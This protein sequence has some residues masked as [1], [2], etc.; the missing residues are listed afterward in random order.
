MVEGSSRLYLH[1]RVNLLLS[2]TVKR[3][4]KHSQHVKSWFLF[5]FFFVFKTNQDKRAS[6]HILRGRKKP[7]YFSPFLDFCEKLTAHQVKGCHSCLSPYS[8]QR[9]HLSFM[10]EGSWQPYRVTAGEPLWSSS[11]GLALFCLWVRLGMGQITQCC[12]AG[13][14]RGCL[15]LVAHPTAWPP[16]LG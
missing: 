8:N 1:W 12:G 13:V 2:E 7:S 14:K 6:K 11:I 16:R 4:L 15:L 5:F 9:E 10:W 3:T